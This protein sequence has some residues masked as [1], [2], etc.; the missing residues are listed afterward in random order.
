MTFPHKT[1]AMKKINDKI[2]VEW[3]SSLVVGWL[4]ENK[5]FGFVYG[6]FS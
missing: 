3:R 6:G 2:L 5:K 1:L 4:Y